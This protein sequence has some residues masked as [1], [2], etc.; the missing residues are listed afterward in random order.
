MEYRELKLTLRE[1]DIQKTV[2][3]TLLRKQAP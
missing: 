3:D 2:V 1:Q